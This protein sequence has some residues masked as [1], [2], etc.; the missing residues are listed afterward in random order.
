MLA[1]LKQYGLP[2]VAYEGGPTNV[3][4]E[5]GCGPSCVLYQKANADPRMGAAV[6]QMFATWFANGGDEFTFYKA[7]GDC[8]QHGCFGALVNLMQLPTGTPKWSAVTAALSGTGI[9]YH[10]TITPVPTPTPVPTNAPTPT[11]VPTATPTPIPTPSPTPTPTPTPSPTPAP[12]ATPT[13]TP[14]TVQFSATPD[15]VK[16]GGSSTIAWHTT[17]ADLCQS[18]GGYWKMALQGKDGTFTATNIQASR[19][20]TLTCVGKNGQVWTSTIAIAV[21]Q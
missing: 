13:S 7:V 21:C 14:F 20:Y 8:T 9:D 3:S 17:G 12:T 5:N 6:S 11:P 18:T 1:A 10:P 19:D 4:N 15:T 16:A 2:M